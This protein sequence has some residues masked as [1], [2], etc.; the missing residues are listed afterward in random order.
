MPRLPEILR[1]TLGELLLVALAAGL[2][3]AAMRAGGLAAAGYLFGVI[4]LT[5]IVL[6]TALVGRGT[7]QAFA[8]GF[9]VG[10]SVYGGVL[11]WY[12]EAELDP[13]LG[14]LLTTR[15][16]EPVY[17]AVR[18]VYYVDVYSGREADVVEAGAA[19][20]RGLSRLGYWKKNVGGP[21]A[22]T[23]VAKV[24]NVYWSP[25]VRPERRDFMQV[26]HLLAALTL[27]YVAGKFG[28]ALYR[29]RKPAPA[30][31]DV[32]ERASRDGEISSPAPGGGTG[33]LR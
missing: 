1:F 4:V 18:E 29:R 19:A 11:Y 15:A 25:Q 14:E 22:S 23:L 26:V 27:G 33:S 28:A 24:G 10:V 16:A 12:G 32:G 2:G 7:L 3:M 6:V 13:E 21:F 31:A 9:L 17:D 30:A 5:A 20:K 8:I